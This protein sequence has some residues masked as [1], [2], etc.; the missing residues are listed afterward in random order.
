MFDITISSILGNII[1]F[2]GDIFSIIIFVFAAFVLLLAILGKKSAT[3]KENR[4]AL[5]VLVVDAFALIFLFA[6]F[7]GKKLTPGL[8]SMP[9][10]VFFGISD[11]LLILTFILSLFLLVA[12]A[13][14]Y[15]SD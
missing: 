4:G 8:S 14:I 13:F 2:M 15:W 11:S 1:V 7:I 5:E 6:A 12:T 10:G 3:I 9:N